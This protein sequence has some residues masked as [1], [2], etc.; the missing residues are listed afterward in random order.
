MLEMGDAAAA[1]H[2]DVGRLAAASNLDALVCVGPLSAT[3]AAAATAAGLANV[4][5]LATTADAAAAVPPMLRAGDLVLLK[6]SRGMRLEKVAA[7]I[8]AAFG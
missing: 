5:H 6:A 8:H 4:S 7:A 1:G 3:I 2:A